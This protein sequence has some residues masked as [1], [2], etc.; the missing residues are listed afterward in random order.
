MK[1]KSVKKVEME[2]NPPI[3]EKNSKS[4]VA[5]IS[6]ISSVFIV[7]KNIC[8]FANPVGRVM[9]LESFALF[10]W[11]KGVDCFMAPNY[12]DLN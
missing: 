7:S 12:T 11:D 4:P 6:F 1:I 5:G 8:T 3:S 10:R 9:G 2:D